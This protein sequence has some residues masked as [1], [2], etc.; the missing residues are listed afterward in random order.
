MILSVNNVRFSYKSRPVLNSVSFSLKKNEL[1]AI[2]GPNGVGKTTLLKCINAI[3]RPQGGSVLVGDRDLLSLSR[4]EIAKDIAYVAQRTETGRLTV[5][6]AILLGRRPHIRWKVGREDLKKVD[7]IIR[8]FGLEDL[9]LRFLDEMSGGELQKVSIA[10]ALVQEPEVLLLD[11]PTSSLDLKNQQEIL[12]TIRH[13]VTGH[14]MAGIMTMHDLNSALRF[15]DKVLFMKNGEIYSASERSEVTPEVVEAVY[16][17][18]VIIEK[19]RGQPV[20][21]PL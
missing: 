5:F 12:E 20:V 15:A 14:G 4:M 6:D 8:T 3:L 9:S 21:M 17:L 1:L 2:L 19:V 10:R 18:P 13:I 11:E 16:G 7:A